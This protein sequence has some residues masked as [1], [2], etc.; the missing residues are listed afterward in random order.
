MNK[1]WDKIVADL[2]SG[3]ESDEHDT[4][5]IASVRKHGAQLVHLAAQLVKEVPKEHANAHKKAL[6]AGAGT[7]PTA[8]IQMFQ[9]MAS[10]VSKH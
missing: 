7:L 2:S 5:N 10:E 6:A 1:D 4:P 3:E 8:A 9:S